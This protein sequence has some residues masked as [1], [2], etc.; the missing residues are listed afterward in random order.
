MDRVITSLPVEDGS[1]KGLYTQ[2]VETKGIKQGSGRMHRF[3][4]CKKKSSF[5][6]SD[7]IL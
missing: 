5:S 7:G 1:R 3:K 2:D 4:P 6:V